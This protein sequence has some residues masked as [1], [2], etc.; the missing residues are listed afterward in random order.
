MMSADKDYKLETIIA[1]CGVESD[2]Q[3]G[4]VIPP[5]HMS[6]TYSF[7][8]FRKIRKYDYSR[9]GNPTRDCLG[10]ALAKMEKGAG[11]VITSSGMAALLTAFHLAD[12]GDLIIAPHDCYGGTHR[13]LSSLHEKGFFTVEF[14]DQ[15]DEA[16]V[17]E[18]FAKKP[19]LFLIETPSNPLLRVVDIESITKQK[20]DTIVIADN[21]FLSPVLQ[22]PIDFGVDVVVHSTTKYINGHSDIVGGAVIGATQEL[23]D[24]LA[25]WA[26]NLGVTGAPLDSFLT[27]RGLRTIELRVRQQ[28]ENA[29]K[30]AL[31]LLD[32]PKVKQVYYPGLNCHKGHE[33]A[34]RQQHG[35]GSMVS[36]E[37]EEGKVDLRKFFA[38]I[39][40][41]SLAESLGGT[42]SLIAHPPSMT[43]AAMDEKAREKA[44]ITESMIRL[45]I[46]LEHA[47]D[48]INDLDKA[49]A[50]A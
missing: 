36:F 10:E 2:T 49:L 39:S 31:F 11:A 23:H 37:V 18:A 24:K 33:I 25:W 8:E 26:N 1:R 14:I 35:F 30:I 29:A 20:G 28:E 16:A 50:A 40:L 27:L 21:T 17:K 44:G 38:A 4:A 45:S 34:A 47:D 7:E 12:Q 22:N 15:S 42:E 46:G 6:S 3:H 41:Y 19:K 9:S 48:L 43:H 5:I 32:H 13:Q